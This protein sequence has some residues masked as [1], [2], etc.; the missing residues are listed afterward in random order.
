MCSIKDTSKADNK[1]SHLLVS[2][3]IWS[4]ALMTPSMPLPTSMVKLPWWIL[5]LT[6]DPQTISKPHLAVLMSSQP[7]TPS[8][9]SD[10]VNHKLSLSRLLSWLSR[11]HLCLPTHLAIPWTHSCGMVLLGKQRRTCTQIYS[12]LATAIISIRKSLS[13]SPLYVSTMVVCAD[14]R[15]YLMLRIII[16]SSNEEISSYSFSDRK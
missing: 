1:L 16:R 8:L 5:T 15:S 12:E 4:L 10:L 3:R 13:T 6:L 7:S 11:R 9:S 14:V 2:I